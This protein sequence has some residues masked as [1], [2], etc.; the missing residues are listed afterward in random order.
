MFR[1]HI[2]IAWRN[3]LRSK[4][5]STVNILGL[6]AG[7]ASFIAVLLFLNH[8]LSYDTWDESLDRVYKLSMKKGSDIKE[9]TPA[10]LASFLVEKHSEIQTGTA[11][12]S[13]GDRE[14]QIDANQKTLFQE[15]I[16]MV[17]SLFLKVF[18]YT[19]VQ[20][21]K[22]EALNPPNAVVISK[23]VAKKL[24]GS[25][26]PMGETIKIYNSIEGTI[27]G[28]MEEPSTPSHLNPNV[29]V[30]DPFQKQNN[31]W[32]N[33]S[34]ETYIKTNV[35][36]D[37]R[38][39]E[40]AINRLYYDERLSGN[41]LSFEQYL[42]SNQ[43]Q[44]FYTDVVPRLHN[45]PKYGNSNIK[46]IQALFLLAIL[47]LIV[48]TI[49]FSNLSVAK[50]MGR[51]K[52]VGVRKVLGSGKNR[53]IAQ[54][55]IETAIQCLISLGFAILIIQLALPS[56]NSIFGLELSL[57]RQSYTASMMGQLFLC[58]CIITMLSGLYPAFFMSKF[59]AVQVLKGTPSKGKG[60]MAFRNF[61]LVAQFVITGFFM[62][63]MVIMTKQLYFMQ[64][65]DRGFSEEQL[66]RI[67]APQSIREQGFDNLKSQL[68][69]I[70]GIEYV[71]KTTQ[72]PGDKF[73]D[74]TTIGFSV[75][76]EKRRFTSVKVSTDYF[77]TLQVQVLEGRDFTDRISDQKTKNAIVNTAAAKRISSES[78]IGKTIYYE[79]CG[80]PM[81]IV[82]V[83]G[84]F[85]VMMA[86]TQIQPTVFTVGNE[87]CRYQS[88]G[89]ILVKLK[90][91]D[92]RASISGIK[93]VWS[94]I[95][96]NAPMRYSFLDD[97]FELLLVSYF[98]LQKTITFFGVIAVLISL[99][100][101]FAL[102]AFITR[103]RNREIGIRKVL[104]A[105]ISSIT[106]LIGKDFLILVS[107]A[108][109][110]AIPLGWWAM[111]RWLQ[112]F[113]YKVDV[114]WLTYVFVALGVVL[115]A[116][117]AVSIQSIKA[118]LANPVESLRTE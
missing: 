113:A 101:L 37:Q 117:A 28:V 99:I 4:A 103:Q 41:E 45:Y 98:R 40:E 115:I 11:L 24:F 49:N 105:E 60:G 58:L 111:K 5:Y 70:A 62:V 20:G 75:N 77:K 31:F 34:F 36:I 25:K 1:N 43:H 44:K 81:Q 42:S 51:M 15:G 30:R 72:V 59:S 118:A 112:I 109:L 9:T 66:M 96:P 91:D 3:L 68:T 52:E 69:A 85:N 14:V 116:L 23:E 71:A 78:V 54:F 17:D 6:A 92:L 16:T 32:E 48:G 46:S 13:S 55:M 97:N 79:G 53:L 94:S 8:E 107:I 38:Q 35:S 64:E 26:N 39:I 95:S 88:G 50:S 100:G 108:V 47:L 61:L 106:K 86:D 63:T 65:R 102:T 87:A 19:L 82:G 76:G 27:T 67:E 89:A 73:V 2:K 33:Y 12:L 74:S 22:D 29:L 110:I 93:K 10:P 21:S 57:W 80:I 114:S 84:D 18:P 83:V 7:L 56:I 104:G 90:S